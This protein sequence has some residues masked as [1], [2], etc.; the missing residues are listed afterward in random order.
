MGRQGHFGMAFHRPGQVTVEDL[1]TVD[2]SGALTFL[3]S[4]STLPLFSCHHCHPH[5]TPPPY[6]L[7]L[8]FPFSSISLCLLHACPPCRHGGLSQTWWRSERIF[9]CF[10]VER[11]DRTSPYPSLYVSLSS[12][13]AFTPFPSTFPGAHALPPLQ[14]H[15]FLSLPG[16]GVNRLFPCLRDICFELFYC[17]PFTLAHG[18]SWASSRHDGTRLPQHSPVVVFACFWAW[19]G[20]TGGQQ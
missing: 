18:L 19:D 15:H 2:Q 14:K 12:S 8:F 7:L 1:V 10:M 16:M 3:F 5:P 11:D 13:L 6:S 20:R 9:S 17:F 4:I